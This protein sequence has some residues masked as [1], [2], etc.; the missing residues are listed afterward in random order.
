MHRGWFR[1][2]AVPGLVL[3]SACLGRSAAKDNSR[4]LGQALTLVNS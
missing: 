3:A 2:L 4:V 1:T